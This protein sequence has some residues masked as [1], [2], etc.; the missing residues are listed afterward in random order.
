MSW[1]Y[2]FTPLYW[3]KGICCWCTR[4][5][6]KW[7]VYEKNVT[8]L[9][10]STFKKRGRVHTSEEIDVERK[11]M[12]MI[13]QKIKQKQKHIRGCWLVHGFPLT[14]TREFSCIQTTSTHRLLGIILF[15]LIFSG[16]MAGI[17]DKSF[18]FC[19]HYLNFFFLLFFLDSHS[20]SLF[21][22]AVPP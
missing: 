22:C 1:R 6:R 19:D 20:L 9:C 16:S 18:P 5:F 21:Y 11:Q 14:P 7:H 8:F 17:H 13:K 2:I 15:L 4:F 3:W 12:T 10:H